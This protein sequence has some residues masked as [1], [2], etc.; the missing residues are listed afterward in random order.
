[1]RRAT[2]LA[3]FWVTICSRGLAGISAV[4]GVYDDSTV[5]FDLTFTAD[6]PLTSGVEFQVFLDADNNGSTGYGRGYEMLV[7]AIPASSSTSTLELRAAQC[8]SPTS[9]GTGGWGDVLGSA[10]FTPSG[11]VQAGVSLPIAAPG[12]TQGSLTFGVESYL[13]GRLIDSRHG[14][15]T[16]SGGGGTPDQCPD[17]PNKLLP[18]VC[19]CGTPD[20]DVNGNGVMDCLETADCVNSVSTWKNYVFEQQSGVFTAHFDA[21]PLGDNIDGLISLSQG[22]TAQFADS[23]V[24]PRFNRDGFIDAYD[25]RVNW[26]GAQTSVPYHAGF[27]YHFRLEVDVANH[28]YSAYVTPPGG[29]S[30]LTVAQDYRFRAPQAD[31]SQLDH[32]S[33]WAGVGS[34]RVCHF[35][36]GVCARDGD[37]D[38][39]SDCNDGCPRDSKKTSPGVCGCGLVDCYTWMETGGV[40]DSFADDQ[41]GQLPT[42]WSVETPA[43]PSSFRVQRVNNNPALVAL[44]STSESAVFLDDSAAPLPD[45]YWF[46][47]WLSVSDARADIGLILMA[48]EIGGEFAYLLRSVSGGPFQLQRRTGEADRLYGRRLVSSV[49]PIPDVWYRYKVEVVSLEEINGVRAKIWPEGDREPEDWTIEGIDTSPL[50]P[51]SGTIGLWGAG[52]GEKRFDDLVVIPTGCDIDTDGDGFGDNCDNCPTLPNPLQTDSNGD[53]VGDQCDLGSRTRTDL[54]PENKGGIDGERPPAEPVEPNPTGGPGSD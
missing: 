4:S 49:A 20:V 34:H 38:G 36:A 35:A 37:G 9:C 16:S 53:G 46:F 3:L 17:D 18:A 23:A 39:V 12:P 54:L 44:S 26:Y 51:S 48:N 5:R 8:P 30:E 19:G 50:R 33:V 32:W 7:R 15:R 41:M 31:V 28:M 27:S 11:T 13:D 42:R 43:G 14:L 10:A 52:W 24:T 1:M 6:T 22:A 2:I 29:S 47:G 25:A 45:A 40:A 21:I